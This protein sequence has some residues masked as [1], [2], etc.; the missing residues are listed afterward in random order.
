MNTPSQGDPR[1]QSVP[2]L[3]RPTPEMLQ[4]MLCELEAASGLV[5]KL[6]VHGNDDAVVVTIRNSL[7]DLVLMLEGGRRYE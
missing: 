5:E 2:T 6:L 3:P 1:P 7:R 4:G